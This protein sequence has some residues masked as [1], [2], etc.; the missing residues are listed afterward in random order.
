[1]RNPVLP[2]FMWGFQ[3]H[4]RASME[5]EARKGLDRLGAELAVRGFLV[6]VRVENATFGHP[7]CLEPAEDPSYPPS[8]FAG[9]AARVDEIYDDHPDHRISYG[10]ER[11]SREQPELILRKSVLEAVREVTQAQDRERRTRTFCGAPVRVDDYYVVPALE[12]S[13]AEMASL[14]Q[15]PEAISF[16]SYA[17]AFGVTDALIVRL[18]S[19]ASGALAKKD[20]GRYFD[21]FDDDK[22]GLLR[23]AG[24]AMCKAIGLSLGDVMLQGTFDALNEISAARYEGEEAQGQIVFSPREH[25]AGRPT[26]ALK[27]P[28]PLRS[29]RLARKIVEMSGRDLACFCH[30]AEGLAGLGV[31]VD[32][33]ANVFR[34][35]F[36]GHYQWSLFYGQRLLMKTSF[37]VPSLPSLPLGEHRFIANATRVLPSLTK[38]KAA[39]L[40]T[41]VRAAMDQRHGTMLVVTDEAESEADRLS[42]QALAVEP[43]PLTPEL[44]R[45][46]SG[47]DGAILLNADGICFALGV[48]LDGLATREG[49]PAQGAR[50]NSAIRYVGSRD[51]PTLCV[52][53]SEDGHVTMLPTLKAKVRRSDIRNHVDLL[54]SS[55]VDNYHRAQQWLDKH[56]FYLS[57]EECELVNRELE[58]LDAAP[59]AVGELRY[60]VGMFTPDAQMNNGFYSES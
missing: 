30:G 56:R 11:R 33:Q 48:I 25:P 27:E 14:P 7:V 1:M 8:L 37:G 44:V 3:Q 6:G 19:E 28:V 51:V 35:E 10:D 60:I 50:Y 16:N 22:I 18:L 32:P 47:I 54:R 53:V 38:E 24:K 43:V 49:D 2:Y 9:C 40:W 52:V 55:D 31:L 26:V 58:R 34:V 59:R 42:T 15:L 29:L 4:F 57:A 45:R 5:S 12:L 17:S 41:S 20:P 23:D 21:T 39:S 46:V 13:E 36:T